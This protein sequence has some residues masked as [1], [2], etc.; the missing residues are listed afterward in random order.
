MSAQTERDGE[1]ASGVCVGGRGVLRGH[2][3]FR[4]GERSNSFR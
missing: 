2:I 4:A 1:H 3:G